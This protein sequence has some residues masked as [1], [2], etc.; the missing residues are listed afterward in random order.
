M[1]D[2]THGGTAFGEKLQSNRT[3]DGNW[4]ISAAVRFGIV[5]IASAAQRLIRDNQAAVAQTYSSK[6]KL[7]ATTPKLWHDVEH[8]RRY[9][10]RSAAL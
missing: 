8:K 10:S 9:P 1:V 3:Q 7:L 4:P 2:R 6:A 5:G